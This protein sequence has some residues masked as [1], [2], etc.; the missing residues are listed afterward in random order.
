MDFIRKKLEKQLDSLQTSRAALAESGKSRGHASAGY[1]LPGKSGEPF[2]FGAWPGK[3]EVLA[4]SVS[5]SGP[6]IDGVRQF[7][8]K[9]V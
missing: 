7:L 3:V 9:N 2:T 4:T 8:V 6:G 5:A 1:A